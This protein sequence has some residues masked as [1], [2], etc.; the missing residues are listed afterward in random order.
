MGMGKKAKMSLILFIYI[1]AVVLQLASAELKP[2]L[3]DYVMIGIATI[4]T[5]FLIYWIWIG[6]IW[7]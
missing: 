2:G 4:S 6:K 5:P 7:K 1:L 3:Y